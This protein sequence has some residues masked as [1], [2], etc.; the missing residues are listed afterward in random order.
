MFVMAKRI[1][2]K[3]DFGQRLASLRKSK[4]ITQI[5]LAAAIGST[6][7]AISYYENEGGYPPAPIVGEL[8]KAIGITSDELLGLSGKKSSKK[9]SQETKRLWKKFQ[10]IKQLPEKDQ[11]AI[12]RMI[13]SLVQA[14]PSH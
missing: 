4:G 12:I 11:R 10:Q 5:D 7:R 6:Q 9:E 8:A 13:N 14:L 1:K 2:R 3:T